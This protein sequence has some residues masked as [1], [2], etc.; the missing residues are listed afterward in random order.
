MTHY[1]YKGEEISHI[2]FI[3]LCQSIGCCGGRKMSHYEKL[4]DMAEKGNERAANILKDLEITTTPNDNNKEIGLYSPKN[5]Y[6]VEVYFPKPLE[7]LGSV[8]SFGTM[9]LDGIEDQIRKY[10]M[11]QQPVVRVN[12][13]EN[14]KKYPEFEWKTVRTFDLTSK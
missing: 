4:V 3:S 12:I 14:L 1:I 6:H 5:R 2:S 8:V 13:Q 7:N 11:Y 9:S 10:W